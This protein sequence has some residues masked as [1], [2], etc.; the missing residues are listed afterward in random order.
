V[1]PNGTDH[2]IFRLGDE[3]S[4]RLP[5]VNGRLGLGSKELEWLPRLAPALPVSVSVPVA[6][7]RPGHGYPWF[8]RIHTWVEGDTVPLEAI[9]ADQA[10]HDLAAL[11]KCLQKCLQSV[12]SEGAPVGRGV[13]LALS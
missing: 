13:T 10:A 12:D 11:I 9:D 4:V 7:G 8:W 3:L 1:L 5:R 6:E 2:A